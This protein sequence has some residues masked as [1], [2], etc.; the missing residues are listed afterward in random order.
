MRPVVGSTLGICAA[1]ACGP[2]VATEGAYAAIDSTVAN[3]RVEVAIRQPGGSTGTAGVVLRADQTWSQFLLAEVTDAGDVILWRYP[4]WQVVGS[5]SVSLAPGAR[6]VLTVNAY[7]S[8]IGVEWNH[9][10]LFSAP[11]TFGTTGT[12]AGIYLGTLPS[13]RPTLDDFGIGDGTVVVPLPTPAPGVSDTF[14]RTV[15]GTTLGAAQSG[16]YWGNVDGSAW[17]TCAGTLACSAGPL[18]TESYARIETGLS[19][20]HITTVLPARPSGAGAQGYA[21]VV[22]RVS[23]SGQTFVWVGLSPAGEVWVYEASP[24]FTA[25]PNPGWNETLPPTMLANA[26]ASAPRTLNVDVV[27]TTVTISVV[28]GGSTSVETT[29]TGGTLAGIYSDNV[30]GSS[31]NWPRFDSFSVS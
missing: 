17:T 13:T 12:Y 20:Q 28:G 7:G 24:T 30:D 10:P 16:Q 18:G 21:G 19:N 8:T 9:V 6:D 2:T 1:A 27:G 22:A 26:D 3:H 23:A 4:G 29:I 14:N 25:T 15:S 11:D 5:G 31:T